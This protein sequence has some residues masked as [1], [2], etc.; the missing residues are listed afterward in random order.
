MKIRE[1][2]EMQLYH[3]L[4]VINKDIDFYNDRSEIVY[5][6]IKDNCST[7]QLN[8][9]FIQLTKDYKNYKGITVW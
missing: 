6:A 1:Q 5:Q 7:S 2:R 9:I 4:K 8:Q 3:I